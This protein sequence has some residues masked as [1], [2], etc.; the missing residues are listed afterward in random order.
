MSKQEFDIDKVVQEAQ[1]TGVKSIDQGKS[2]YSSQ[3]F[4][5]VC[6]QG[7]LII[8]APKPGG[9]KPPQHHQQQIGRA[10]YMPTRYLRFELSL[11]ILL[12]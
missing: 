2:G 4:N 6:D 5:V 1:L 10:S 3:S 8:L 11:V 12:C 7:E 9:V